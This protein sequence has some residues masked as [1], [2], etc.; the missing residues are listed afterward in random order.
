[1]RD[2]R[3]AAA[4]LDVFAGEPDL[5]PAYFDLPTLFML[6]HIGSS[7]REARRGMGRLLVDGLTRWARGE[8]AP[9]QLR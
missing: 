3:V 2:G 1:L 7:T 4:G 9:N 8:R 6:P 5:H